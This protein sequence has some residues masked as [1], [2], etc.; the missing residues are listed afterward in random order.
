MTR[1]VG[2]SLIVLLPH[3]YQS[4]HFSPWYEMMASNT[5][6]MEVTFSK[7]RYIVYVAVVTTN[8]ILSQVQ[9]GMH[10]SDYVAGFGNHNYGCNL[11]FHNDEGEINYSSLITWKEVLDG[12]QDVIQIWSSGSSFRNV[13]QKFCDRRKTNQGLKAVLNRLYPEVY[14]DRIQ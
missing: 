1:I 5:K 4:D 7:K 10:Y 14:G 13:Y 12:R 8:P 2:E 6:S 11:I 9:N 3:R